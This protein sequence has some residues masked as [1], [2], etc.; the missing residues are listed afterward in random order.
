M[1]KKILILSLM[2]LL[3]VAVN[4]Q[5]ISSDEGSGSIEENTSTKKYLK[6]KYTRLELDAIA[7]SQGSSKDGF[8]NERLIVKIVKALKTI[9]S[10]YPEVGQIHSDGQH[11]LNSLII[12]LTK[13]A[14]KIFERKA[15]IVE[16]NFSEYVEGK[17]GIQRLD[18]FNAKYKAASIRLVFDF[19]I[20]E[21]QYPM[22]IS[23]LSKMYET[24]PEVAYVETNGI[25]GDRY[26]IFLIQKGKHWHFVFKHGRGDCPAGCI[27]EHYYYYTYIPEKQ[28]VIKNGELPS[29]RSRAGGIYLWGIPTRRAVRPFS[30]YKDIA[31]KVKDTSSWWVS[32]HGVDVLGYLLTNPKSP[33]YGEDLEPKGH[34]RKIRDDVLA[35]KREALLLL[36]QSLEYPDTS[37]SNRAY[38]HL[39]NITKKDFGRTGVKWKEWLESLPDISQRKDSA[40][41]SIISS[42]VK[43]IYSLLKVQPD[44]LPNQFSKKNTRLSVLKSGVYLIY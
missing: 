16:K 25:V 35:H 29:N 32:L 14:K 5:V 38:Y 8:V 40:Y 4:C 39:K 30:S 44:W 26:E 43:R 42:N 11:A 21:F 36:I 31:K 7:L 2:A 27:Y 28:K 1:L 18:E 13:D 19:L 37:V 9:Q 6:S 10:E 23:V 41:S 12:G 17:T 15:E 22:D 34:F 3:S 33:S 20:V 24:I